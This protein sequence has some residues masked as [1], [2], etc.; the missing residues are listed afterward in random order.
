MSGSR[1][2]QA[3]NALQLFLRSLP[4]GSMFNIV[5]F[6]K[7]TME[8]LYPRSREYN[9]NTLE[10]ASRYT[11]NLQANLGGTDILSPLRDI[12][13]VEIDPHFPRQIFCLTDGDVDNT[14]EV[15]NFVKKN[16]KETCR[17][18]SF[19]IGAEASKKLVRGIAKY[20]KGKAEFV[21]SGERM[22]KKVMKQLTR[23]L[24]PILKNVEIDWRD[25][26][27]PM[28]YSTYKPFIP[29][30]FSGEKINIYAFLE[31]DR[32]LWGN[33]VITIRGTTGK[34][35]FSWDVVL[36]THNVIEGSHIH[37]LAAKSYIRKLEEDSKLNKEL[38]IRLGTNWGLVTKHT[39]FIAIEERTQEVTGTLQRVDVNETIDKTIGGKS[40]HSQ[41]LVQDDNL[42][43]QLDL[44]FVRSM[45]MESS[46]GSLPSEGSSEEW[47]EGGDFKSVES[48]SKNYTTNKSNDIPSDPFFAPIPQPEV[49]SVPSNVNYSNT[50]IQPNFFNNTT[51]SIG[52]GNKTTTT[53]GS[54]RSG[55]VSPRGSRGLSGPPPPQSISKT[56][57][58]P[59]SSGQNNFDSMDYLMNDLEETNL[60]R[61]RESRSKSKETLFK[62]SGS[63]LKSKKNK[64][65]DI[66]HK[67]KKDKI[68]ET[69]KI[70]R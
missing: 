29:N 58:P 45:Q 49:Q 5:G 65:S 46:L 48:E 52:N 21:V 51:T 50:S 22:E 7:P 30:I 26:P 53:P 40:L 11:A 68:K 18:F 59:P 32:E 36:D 31:S 19:G 69:K 42:H 27:I 47:D 6:G 3:K 66:N 25:L 33:K 16:V 12:F 14:V 24:Q 57:A 4:M 1:M 44:S 64:D 63:K 55:V 8:K 13:S 54:L 60:S 2:N 17:I 38:I 70:G 67:D 23:A 15:L 34:K 10:E 35:E 56:S 39:S 61:K 37:R 20:G 41:G 62:K 28:E 9:E 43:E